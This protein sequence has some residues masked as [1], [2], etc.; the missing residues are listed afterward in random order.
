MIARADDLITP[1][2]ERPDRERC[3]QTLAMLSLV[4]SLSRANRAGGKKGKSVRE[5]TDA[6]LMTME[7]PNMY[8][9]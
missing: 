6:V 1:E 3:W 5:R 7:E 4:L 2:R 8:D 9:V